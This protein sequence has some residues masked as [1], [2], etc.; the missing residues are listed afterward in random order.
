MKIL[1]FIGS[2][3]TGFAI[4]LVLRIVMV[5]GASPEPIPVSLVET[6]NLKLPAASTSGL[7]AVQIKLHWGGFYG[8]KAGESYRIFRL[9]DLDS[10][11]YH[12]MQFEETFDQMP[13]ISQVRFLIPNSDH[14]S[15][16]SLDFIGIRPEYLGSKRLIAD[17]LVA[18]NK[19]REDQG[20][21]ADKIK[22]MM[23]STLSLSADDPF[24][25]RLIVRGGKLFFDQ[26]L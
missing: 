6:P 26:P 15:G 5:S 1:C 3:I 11:N 14:V 25:S 7:A 18:I 8:Y 12:I 4:T 20:M 16:S 21:S 10:E 22:T 24:E 13:S 23:E 9:I 17:E 2:L 19:Y